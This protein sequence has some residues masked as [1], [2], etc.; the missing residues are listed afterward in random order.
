MLTPRKAA[1][2]AAEALAPGF[3]GFLP[4]NVCISM[5]NVSISNK[6]QKG[7]QSLFVVTYHSSCLCLAA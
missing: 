2:A 7:P 3:V 1:F 5:I 4:A 6:F